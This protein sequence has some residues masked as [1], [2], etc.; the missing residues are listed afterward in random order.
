MDDSEATELADDDELIDD[1][2]RALGDNRDAGLESDRRAREKLGVGR[3]DFAVVRFLVEADRRGVSL[4][5]GEIALA[6][7]VSTAATTALVD[8]LETVGL[9]RRERNPTDRRSVIVRAALAEGSQERRIAMTRDAAE[10]RAIAAL[11]VRDR[12]VVLRAL[13]QITDAVRRDGH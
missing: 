6:L 4:T 2:L 12:R 5:P 10:R 8:R 7:G 11:P 1:L 9:V 3:N 13:E